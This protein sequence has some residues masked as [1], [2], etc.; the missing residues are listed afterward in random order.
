LKETALAT[1]G[2]EREIGAPTSMG[3]SWDAHSAVRGKV[4][5]NDKDNKNIKNKF[6]DPHLFIDTSFIVSTFGLG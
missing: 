1:N 6:N 3:F 4:I 5:T 2:P